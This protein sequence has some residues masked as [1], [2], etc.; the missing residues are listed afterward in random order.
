[1]GEMRAIK[2]DML[3]PRHLGPGDHL[4]EDLQDRL[5]WSMES[6]FG[7][8]ESAAVLQGNDFIIAEVVKWPEGEAPPGEGINRSYLMRTAPDV[9]EP[10]KHFEVYKIKGKQA[11][12]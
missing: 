9:T 6:T 10:K 8:G 1:M 12:K 2:M 5:N 11:E 3:A 4:P 7:E